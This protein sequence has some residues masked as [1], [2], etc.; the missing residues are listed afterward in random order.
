MSVVWRFGLEIVYL[1]TMS[2][3]SALSVSISA[4]RQEFNQEVH[5]CAF[6]DR[7]LCIEH[8]YLPGGECYAATNTDRPPLSPVLYL[9]QL[10]YII[11]I[12]KG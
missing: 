12:S 11:A 7:D 3:Y 5:Y 8:C 4:H 1:A 10:Y 6:N 9:C 2:A